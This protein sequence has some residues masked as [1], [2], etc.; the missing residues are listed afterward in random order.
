MALACQYLCEVH[1][2]LDEFSHELFLPPEV[3]ANLLE[4]SEKHLVHYDYCAGYA[5]SRGDKLF[6]VAPKHHMIYHWACKAQFLNPRRCACWVDEDY[7]R[8]I[9][10]IVRSCTAG[11]QLHNIGETVAAKHSWGLHMLHNYGV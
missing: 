5:D 10:Q 9:K 3:A 11:M 2:I 6:T 4:A 1:D 7:V 8:V